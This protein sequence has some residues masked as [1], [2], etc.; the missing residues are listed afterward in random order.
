METYR[1]NDWL[2]TF[3]PVDHQYTVDGFAVVSVTQLIDAVLG[4][5]YKRV[6]PL[7]LQKAAE[8]GTLLHDNIAQYEMHQEKVFHPEMQTYLALK[9]QHHIDVVE[10]EKI[11]IIQHEGIPVA[12]GRFDMI[13][14]SPLIKGL[15]IADVKRS[16]HLNE[17]RL[18]LQ[19]NLYKLGY[20]QTYKQP[21]HYLKCMRIRNRFSEYLDVMIDR[22]STLAMIERYLAQHPIDY[23][24]YYQT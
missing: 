18:K 12:A 21:I 5:P 10:S 4:R 7:I 13:V 20:E 16:L 8:K 9:R 24:R 1:I 22:E 19:L 23:N 2:V 6:D 11:V 14:R 3:S 17:D 15:G